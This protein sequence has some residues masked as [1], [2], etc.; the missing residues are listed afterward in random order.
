MIESLPPSKAPELDSLGAESSIG[1]ITEENLK[2]IGHLYVELGTKFHDRLPGS[3]FYTGTGE[4]IGVGNIY[5]NSI[6]TAYEL[7]YALAATLHPLVRQMAEG[8]QPFDVSAL[9]NSKV[10]RGLRILDL[11]C[12]YQPV[13]ARVARCMGADVWTVDRES[14]MRF[15][16]EKDHFPVD[17][18]KLEIERHIRLDLD[19]PNAGRMLQEL[20]GGEFNLVIEANLNAGGFR[21]GRVIAMPLLR[22]G[23]IYKNTTS[24]PLEGELK[25]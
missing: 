17:Q 25:K 2:N 16:Q 22:K 19:A 23:G 12:G 8:V 11:G 21:E 7:E 5:H 18:Q 15:H 6:V 24:D 14:A 13:F 9:V 3:E 20:T 10:M 4:P 1:E